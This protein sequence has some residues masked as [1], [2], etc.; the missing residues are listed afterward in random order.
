MGLGE[1][2]L[3]RNV[4]LEPEV[5]VWNQTFCGEEESKRVFCL[6][7]VKFDQFCVDFE[8]DKSRF[9]HMP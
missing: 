3:D 2:T 6:I 7:D 8:R 1:W 4:A 5:V 9:D